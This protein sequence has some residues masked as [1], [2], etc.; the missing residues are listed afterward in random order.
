MAD[1]QETIQWLTTRSSGK[2]HTHS[3]DDGQTGWRLHAVP[4]QPSQRLTGIGRVRAL[5]GLRP[6][7]GWGLDLFIDEKCRRCALRAKERT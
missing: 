6:R 7:R 4:A 3:A 5:C 2:S 1:T